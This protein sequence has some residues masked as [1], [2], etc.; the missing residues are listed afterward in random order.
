MVSIATETVLETPPP[1]AD[2]EAPHFC[3]EL[4]HMPPQLAK[5]AIKPGEIRNP[6]GP[7][8]NAFNLRAR[9]RESGDRALAVLLRWM[10]GDD[11]RA[12]I[13]AAKIILEYGYGLAAD[14]PAFTGSR[15][16]GLESLPV[17][18]RVRILRDRAQAMAR[19]LAE[20]KAAQPSPGAVMRAEIE[21]AQPSAQSQQESK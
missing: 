20:A 14:Q 12:A 13:P 10:E 18:E 5:Y 16:P 11:Y 6:L 1:P 4:G 2:A 8:V 21:A 9:C 7:R 17:R 3:R 19:E 15:V